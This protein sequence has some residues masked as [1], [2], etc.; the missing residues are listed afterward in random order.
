MVRHLLCFIGF[1]CSHRAAS[2]SVAGWD[3]YYYSHPC[4][5]CGR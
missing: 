2:I 4:C 5:W 1:H 3:M